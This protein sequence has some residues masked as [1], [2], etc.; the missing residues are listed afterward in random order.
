MAQVF[1]KLPGAQDRALVNAVPGFKKTGSH[2]IRVPETGA[3]LE[4]TE[5]RKK[6]GE[7]LGWICLGLSTVYFG[8]VL[9][10]LA[11][12]QW[13][14]GLDAFIFAAIWFVTGMV[15]HVG[16]FVAEGL[17]GRDAPR[18]VLAVVLFWIGQLVMWMM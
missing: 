8:A 12:Q 10:R 2:G 5:R 6:W 14:T 15:V 17:R 3:A 16:V 11:G 18:A 7:T 9:V 4:L 1:V 13:W